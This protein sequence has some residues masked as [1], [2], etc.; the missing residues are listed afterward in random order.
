MDVFVTIF[1]DY[2]F[3]FIKMKIYKSICNSI[4][5]ETN[6]Y[7]SDATK[8]IVGDINN[9]LGNALFINKFY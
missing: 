1:L 2:F 5:F 8:M 9:R 6:N 4:I 3:H 7:Y